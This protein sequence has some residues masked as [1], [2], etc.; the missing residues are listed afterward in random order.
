MQKYSSRSKYKTP[1]NMAPHHLLHTVP[2]YKGPGCTKQR[3]RLYKELRVYKSV[4][5]LPGVRVTVAESLIR[6][7][8]AVRVSEW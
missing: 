3:P 5:P 2:L 4:A 6:E 8:Q 7:E 1:F